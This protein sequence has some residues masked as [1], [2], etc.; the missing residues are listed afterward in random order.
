MWYSAFGLSLAVDGPV[1]GLIPKAA[2]ATPDIRVWFHQRPAFFNPD[3]SVEEPYFASEDTGA[4][5]PALQ[6]WR[7]A[8][9]AYFRLLYA[10]GTQFLVAG[11]GGDVCVISPGATLED[12]ATYLLGP[13]LG[14]AMRL[15]GSTCLHAS[16]VA[17]DGQ[18]IAIA[19]PAGIL[20]GAGV[21]AAVGAIADALRR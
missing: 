17:V 8:D 3:R 16:V 1:P 12:A 4:A 2:P 10:D 20:T 6:V 14:F 21:G 9:G 5:S 7:T 11:T 13:V 19:G 18:A 15:R